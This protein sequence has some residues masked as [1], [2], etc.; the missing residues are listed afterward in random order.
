M[1][2]W[3]VSCVF[4]W[5]NVG[6]DGG[7]KERGRIGIWHTCQLWGGKG[8]NLTLW[9]TLP[10]K[11]AWGNVHTFTSGL[12]IGLI[13]KLM[14]PSSKTH[15]HTHTLILPVVLLLTPVSITG[16]VNP[17]CENDEWAI[18]HVRHTLLHTHTNTHTLCFLSPSLFH[19]PLPSSFSPGD[20]RS[21]LPSW[22][23]HLP[24]PNTHAHKTLMRSV[25]E[26]NIECSI[27][28]MKSI[29]VYTSAGHVLVFVC[30][31]WVLSVHSW[32]MC[33]KVEDYAFHK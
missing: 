10:H 25:R 1:E 20:L 21:L 6:A 28:W 31:M 4:V 14:C 2:K 3:K 9:H 24:L 13:L 11:H 27:L 32:F 8:V 12:A 15:T 30:L 16:K 5:F 19:Y 29:V 22:S 18:L 7:E 26:T 17:P 23:T 33:V